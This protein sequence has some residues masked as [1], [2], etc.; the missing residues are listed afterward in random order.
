MAACPLLAETPV[1]PPHSEVTVLSTR[2][3]SCR[4]Q[5]HFCLPT[6]Y[7]GLAPIDR[8]PSGGYCLV[9][10]ALQAAAK[11][12]SIV[13]ML[14]REC[15]KIPVSRAFKVS[16]GPNHLLWHNGPRCCTIPAAQLLPPNG[17]GN[18]PTRAE[19]RC[20]LLNEIAAPR[21]MR[22]RIR[23]RPMAG[24][25]TGKAALHSLY[26]IAFTKLRSILNGLSPPHG[27]TR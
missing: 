22:S 25:E 10:Q 11:P 16:I 14:Y 27:A 7:Y 26:N 19:F 18:R 20:A 12:L 9:L 5:C 8:E 23:I 6:V 1:S 21:R 3:D 15:H 24:C 13:E 4:S 17:L 2:S